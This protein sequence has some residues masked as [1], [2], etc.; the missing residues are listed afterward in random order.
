M[1]LQVRRPQL[2]TWNVWAKSWPLVSSSIRG[3]F[4]NYWNVS[5][6]NLL[7]PIWN[8]ITLT[9]ATVCIHTIIYCGDSSSQINCK[10]NQVTKKLTIAKGNYISLT[11]SKSFKSH[12]IPW[13]EPCIFRHLHYTIQKINHSSWGPVYERSGRCTEGSE[14][15]IQ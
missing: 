12:R 9:K 5:A 4:S 3:T 13:Q 7:K 14:V 8:I 11:L 15:A 6:L 2:L 1:V 10:S